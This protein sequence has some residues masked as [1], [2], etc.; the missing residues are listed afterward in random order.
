MIRHGAKRTILDRRDYAYHKTFPHFG[1][2]WGPELSLM[3]YTLDARKTMPDQNADGLPYGCTGYAQTDAKCDQ[4]GVIYDPRY[5][6]FKTCFME[7]HEATT[8]CDIR[9]SAKSLRVYGA[10][11][12]DPAFSNLPMDQ[13]D[14]EARKHK[15]GQTFFI[16]K[17]P[18]RDWFDSFRI[19]L[20]AQ[21]FNSNTPISTGTIWFPEWQSPEITGQL[22]D[23]FVY[24]NLPDEYEWHDY[25]IAG[26][27]TIDGKPT[28]R[29]KSWQGPNYGDHGWVYVGRAAFNRAFD[30]YGT[31]GLTV[32]KASPEDVR[33]IDLD[34]LQTVLDYL[35][36]I[37]DIIGK[38]DWVTVHA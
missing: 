31:T 1:A 14:A 11:P 29:V 12:Y 26:E 34:I 23:Q 32:A 10:L 20:R 9:T 3:E 33:T 38:S 17:A 7:G 5:T 28:M 19:A 18:G 30:I 13:K 15:S 37:L 4:E 6:Y 25:I 35:R 27:H 24:N 2:A 16:D 22:T 21:Y 36:R 8:G